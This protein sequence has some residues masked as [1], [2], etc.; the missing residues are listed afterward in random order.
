MKMNKHIAAITAV[1]GLA[2]V[3]VAAIAEDH[4]FTEEPSSTSPL[5]G[6]NMGN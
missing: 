1:L 4:P 5:F 2:L 6:R 3:S